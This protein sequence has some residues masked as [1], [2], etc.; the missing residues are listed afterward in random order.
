VGGYICFAGVTNA[1]R[2]NIGRSVRYQSGRI[3]CENGFERMEKRNFEIPGIVTP[4]D[5]DGS[6]YRLNI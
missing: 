4:S 1:G 5:L 6:R 3:Q 2:G